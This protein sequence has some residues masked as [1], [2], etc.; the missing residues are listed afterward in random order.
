MSKEKKP[1][2]ASRAFEWK[3]LAVAGALII[4]VFLCETSL[5]RVRPVHPEYPHLVTMSM[6]T[7]LAPVQ[8]FHL[9]GSATL[10]VVFHRRP[11]FS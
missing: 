2:P 5:Y 1:P 8:F 9:L 10:I 6:Y 7:P 3:Y 4:A 11:S